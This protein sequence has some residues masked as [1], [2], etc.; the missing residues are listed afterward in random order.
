MIAAEKT[1]E[2]GIDVQSKAGE[3]RKMKAKLEL[4]LILPNLEILSTLGN[5]YMYLYFIDNSLSLPLYFA[6]FFFNICG[7]FSFYHFSVSR[8]PIYFSKHRTFSL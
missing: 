6:G 3:L 2:V 8:S 1:Q 5:L 4:E 7:R